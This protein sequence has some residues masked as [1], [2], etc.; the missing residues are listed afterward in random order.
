MPKYVKTV[1][2]KSILIPWLNETVFGEN[3]SFLT[4]EE[5]QL[6]QDALTEASTLPGY[7]GQNCVQIGNT[8]IFTHEFDTEENL[9]NFV[10]KTQDKES[11]LYD[12]N[13]A[14]TKYSEMIK[15]KVKELNIQDSFQVTNSIDLN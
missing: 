15:R 10:N 13:M 6:R 1:V 11:E 2:K 7:L 8:E 4:N 9:R 12:E 3:S 5:K 14:I